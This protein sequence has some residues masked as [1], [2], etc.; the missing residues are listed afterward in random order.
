MLVAGVMDGHGGYNGMIASH[1][2]LDTLW[3][4]FQQH[5]DRVQAWSVEEW[6]Q[7]LRHAFALAEDAIR[8]KFL[9]ELTAHSGL[10]NDHYLDAQSVVRRSNG[11]PVRGGTTCTVT[12]V[13]LSPAGD[14]ASVI[15]ANVG[16]SMAMLVPTWCS[17]SHEAASQYQYQVLTS[18]HTPNSVHEYARMQ[19]L[20]LASS[21][22]L[23]YDRASVKRKYECPA[24]FTPDGQLD[25]VV[26]SN[27]WQFGLHP[28]NVRM[29]PAMY[30]VTPRNVTVDATCLQMT[31]TLGDFYAH[32]FGVSSEPEISVHHV[33]RDQRPE[34]SELPL[35]YLLVIAS[36]GK[37]TQA[38]PMTLRTFIIPAPTQ[39]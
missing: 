10:P 31:R 11:H 22:R 24:V 13:V 23:V 20:H 9:A 39:H 4:F 35:S 27:P 33:V 28:A 34:Q 26:A 17:S 2:A 36:D 38:H 18:N 21:L 5:S 15:T 12:V 37:H 1:V 32:Q 25:P 29:E 8:Q 19:S 7:R 14:E 6:Q 16:D 30:G 3:G